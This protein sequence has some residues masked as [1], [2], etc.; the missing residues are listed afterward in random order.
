MQSP[1]LRYRKLD[2]VRDLQPPATRL[3][4]PA[5]SQLRLPQAWIVF[6]R[7]SRTAMKRRRGR[8]EVEIPP[9]AQTGGGSGSASAAERHAPAKRAK[10]V[11]AAG[12]PAATA[13]GAEPALDLVRSVPPADDGMMEEPEDEST[14]V[15]LAPQH[16]PSPA[17]DGASRPAAA[18]G[19]QQEPSPAPP[20]PWRRVAAQRRGHG[21]AAA[22]AAKPAAGGPQGGR[23]PL[24]CSG[25]GSLY[26]SQLVRLQQLLG[27]GA[28]AAQAPAAEA[29]PTDS[30]ESGGAAWR[31]QA[32]QRTS[33][34]A[35]WRGTPA[36]AAR[37]PGGA[38]RGGGGAGD[39][40]DD[41]E[42][43]AANLLSMALA[44]EA[45]EAA[46]A[47]RPA[48]PASAACRTPRPPP[49]ARPRPAAAAAPP[50][51][52]RGRGPAATC[53][54]VSP[55]EVV[56]LVESEAGL[57]RLAAALPPAAFVAVVGA[58]EALERAQRAASAAAAAVRAVEGVLAAKLGEAEAA[59]A[60]AGAAARQLLAHAA[61]LGPVA[62][63]GAGR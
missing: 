19:G 35:R 49:P 62:P 55:S 8:L 5:G 23:G 63:G 42:V 59:R 18:P 1:T 33:L 37:S 14:Q 17:T 40:D 29:V 38:R 44:A 51:D 10:G 3:S 58:H 41:E 56:A 2:N 53:A 54:T 47:L 7:R 6:K 15:A 32:P 52:A 9:A 13:S 26:H 21:P 27:H 61:S 28:A 60:A 46:A 25:P 34:H 11:R 30:G 57:R 39:T 20:L 50:P 22:L 4:V 43:A 45:T 16:V 48:P 36:A 31:E 12:A 24:G